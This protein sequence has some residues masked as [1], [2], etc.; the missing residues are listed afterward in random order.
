MVNRTRMQIAFYGSTRNY[1]FQFDDLGYE[2][3]TEQLGLL[4]K[5]GDIP[6][7]ANLISDDMLEHFAVVAKWD[8]MA[9]AL[10]DR[11][12]GVASRV[13]TYLASED[14]QRH[15]ENLAKWGEIAKAVK[16]G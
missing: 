10:I 14:I 8:D 15:P 4:M 7:M 1:A 11:Y 6:G 9:D 16:L 12:Q 5:Q 13:V 3:I 2:G